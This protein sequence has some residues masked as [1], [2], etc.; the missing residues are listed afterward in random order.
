[1]DGCMFY[2]GCSEKFTFLQH[3]TRHIR[4]KHDF[5][6]PEGSSHII[7]RLNNTKKTTIPSFVDTGET[8]QCIC[9]GKKKYKH[10]EFI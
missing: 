5:Q 8:Y 2:C 7:M 10:K 4:S 3:F 9:S 1:M 6:I